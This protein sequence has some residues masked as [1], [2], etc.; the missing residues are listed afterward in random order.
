MSTTEELLGRKSSGS[1]PENRDYGRRGSVELTTRQPPSAKFS[2]N[3]PTS[4]GRSVGMVRSRTQATEF[5]FLLKQFL[6]HC[7]LFGYP[8]VLLHLLD[9]YVVLCC[10]SCTDYN[11]NAVF[12]LHSRIS[13]WGGPYGC[14]QN[15]VG[16]Q[17]AKQQ[18]RT[19]GLHN[20]CDYF[21]LCSGL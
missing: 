17:K 15:S 21:T 9:Q 10:A 18:Q 2:T 4:G 7:S 20:V 11:I 13:Y 12:K 16:T 1:G 8:I 5:V 14:Q 19:P 3:Q 6:P